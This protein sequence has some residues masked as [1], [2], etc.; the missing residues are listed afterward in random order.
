MMQP[1]REAWTLRAIMIGTLSR[2]CDD[3]VSNR[4]QC[5]AGTMRRGLTDVRRIL[6]AFAA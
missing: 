3:R 5:G 1:S 4:D 2:R 6:I